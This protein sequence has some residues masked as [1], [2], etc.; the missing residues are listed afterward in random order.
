MPC[1][2]GP[3]TRKLWEQVRDLM[4]HHDQMSDHYRAENDALRQRLAE[5]ETEIRALRRMLT[6]EPRP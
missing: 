2:C 6:P 5:A 1:D 4:Q 3:E